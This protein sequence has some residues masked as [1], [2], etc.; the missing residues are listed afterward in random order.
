MEV[1]VGLN[2]YKKSCCDE[3]LRRLSVIDALARMIE[4]Q[5]DISNEV[6]LLYKKIVPPREEANEWVYPA[7]DDKD[8][9]YS[10]CVNVLKDLG[11]R[12]EQNR[13]ILV[14]AIMTI[15]LTPALDGWY[16]NMIQ[17]VAQL[18]ERTVEDQKNVI[19]NYV[20]LFNKNHGSV[21]W[22]KYSRCQVSHRGKNDKTAD[23]P[24]DKKLGRNIHGS[25][26]YKQYKENCEKN[27]CSSKEWWCSWCRPILC[28]GDTECCN[29]NRLG[30]EFV[31]Y[32]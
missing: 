27:D 9:H 21:S 23:V 29:E 2:L 22:G 5:N 17:V 30:E 11:D 32:I 3:F 19:E 12:F 16:H 7:D 20:E 15:P 10:M 18:T 6:L 14:E 25:R 1:R 4:G 8:G 24:I 28:T 31:A 26:A 13:A